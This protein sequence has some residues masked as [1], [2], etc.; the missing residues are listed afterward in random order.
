MEK[1]KKLKH[2][3]LGM[4]ML[5]LIFLVHGIQIIINKRIKIRYQDHQFHKENGSFK[6]QNK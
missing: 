5:I 2:I 6:N 4:K 1:L 3:S